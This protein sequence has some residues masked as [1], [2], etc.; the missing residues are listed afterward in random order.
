MTADSFRAGI[1]TVTSQRFLSAGSF[2]GSRHSLVLHGCH[3]TK[4][5]ATHSKEPTT[6]RISIH[7]TPNHRYALGGASSGSLCSELRS[8]QRIKTPISDKIKKTRQNPNQMLLQTG[9][10][11][12]IVVN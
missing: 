5:N 4:S 2:T 8:P 10:K 9:D 3:G 7:P 11:S 1:S 6:T 12:S